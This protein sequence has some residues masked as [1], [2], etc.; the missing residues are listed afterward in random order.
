VKKSKKMSYRRRIIR[1]VIVRKISIAIF[2][3]RI[4]T[5]KWRL[6]VIS[7]RCI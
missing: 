5:V 3:R 7:L 6:R 2:I 1:G 4:H